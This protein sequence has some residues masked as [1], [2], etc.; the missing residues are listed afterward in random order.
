MLCAKHILRSLVA[1]A[2]EDVEQAFRAS[3][4]NKEVGL[5]RVP[6]E[7]FRLAPVVF[8]EKPLQ[9]RTSRGGR[10]EYK[11]KCC[12][13]GPSTRRGVDLCSHASNNFNRLVGLEIVAR[14]MEG[15]EET[16]C[17]SSPGRSSEIASFTVR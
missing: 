5:D 17:S 2:C 13:A 16:L 11:K 4:R 6:N 9:A 3:A 15:S 10:E 8:A 1:L 12:G 14:L 7:V